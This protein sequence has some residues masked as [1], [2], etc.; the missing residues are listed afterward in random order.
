LSESKVVKPRKDQDFIDVCEYLR[1]EILGYGDDMKITKF[2]ALRIKGLS[3]GKFIAN[4]K[5]KPMAQY[6][7]TTILFTLKICKGMILNGF[8]RNTFKN[9]AHRFNYCMTIVE[10]EINDVCIRLKSAKKYKEK[11]E[12]MKLDNMVNDGA[13]Y[14]PKGKDTNKNL[15]DLW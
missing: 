2:M 13:E 11:A 3:N 12:T 8:S 14:T 5:T 15:C 4:K 1:S 9:E 10:N 6:D 7:F